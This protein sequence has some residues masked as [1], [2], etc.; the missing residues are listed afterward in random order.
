MAGQLETN[1]NNDKMLL[2]IDGFV[3]CLKILS[4]IETF[5]FIFYPVIVFTEVSVM[6]NTIKP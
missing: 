1:Y 6:G 2:F 3:Y 4:R 5:Y